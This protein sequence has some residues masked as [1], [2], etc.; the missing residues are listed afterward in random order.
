[1]KYSLINHNEIKQLITCEPCTDRAKKDRDFDRRRRRAD[2]ERTLRCVAA[3]SN[4]AR[5][6]AARERGALPQ[7][8]A[9]NSAERGDLTRKNNNNTNIISLN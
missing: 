7:R 1:M 2:L 6:K 4:E 3:G 5:I 8:R 9:A